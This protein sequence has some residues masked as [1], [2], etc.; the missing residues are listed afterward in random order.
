MNEPQSGELTLPVKE[1]VT[2]SVS[3]ERNNSINRMSGDASVLSALTMDE[4]LKTMG[5]RSVYTTRQA[6]SYAA[7]K[8]LITPRTSM[9]GRLSDR[10]KELQLNNLKMQNLPLCGRQNELE[11]LTNA[12]STIQDG[13]RG[14][15]L[16]GGL[17]GTG[18]T[19]LI[20]HDSF[21][22]KVRAQGGIFVTAKCDLREQNEPFASVQDAMSLLTEKILLLPKR[23][24]QKPVPS[25]QNLVMNVI[26]ESLTGEEK[27]S[28]KFS[29]SSVPTD[30]SGVSSLEEVQEKLAVELTDNEWGVLIQTVP[31]MEALLMARASAEVGVPMAELRLQQSDEHHTKVDGT[32]L[33]TTINPLRQSNQKMDGS[34][35]RENSD[36][37]KYAYRHFIRS[38]S[39]LCP[40]VIVFDDCQWQDKASMEWMKSILTDTTKEISSRGHDVKDGGSPSLLIV[41]SY[42][43]EEVDDD[44]G[45]MRMTKELN[46]LQS[47]QEK[48]VNEFNELSNPTKEIDRGVSLHIQN[49]Q[50]GNLE[51]GD[52]VGILEELLNCNGANVEELAEII[53]KKTA[54]NAFFVVQL[55]VRLKEDNRFTFNIGLMKWT[56]DCS[57]IRE[58]YTATSNVADFLT[59]RMKKSGA[60]LAILPIAAAL[61]NEFSPGALQMVIDRVKISFQKS[62]N[63]QF[64]S[65]YDTKLV[66]S[67]LLQCVDEGL[68]ESTSNGMFKFCHDKILETAMSFLSDDVKVCIGDYFLDQFDAEEE[69]FGDAFY[70]LLSLV[71]QRVDELARSEEKKFR[72]VQ[73]NTLA[74]EKALNCAAFEP[75]SEFLSNAIRCLPSDHWTKH[76]DLSLHIFV[77][78]GAAAFNAGAGHVDRVKRYTDEVFAQ[79]DV[80]LLDK[81]DLCYTMMD[82]YDSAFTAESNLANY[83]FGRSLLKDFGCRFPKSSV[84]VLLRTLSGLLA[85]KVTLKKKLSPQILETMPIS[86]DRKLMAVMKILDKF[87]NAAFHSKTDLLPLVMFRQVQYTDKF[88]LSPY[89]ALAYPLLGM[90]FCSMQDFE[91]SRICAQAGLTILGRCN[92]QSIASRCYLLVYVYNMHW[93]TPL[94]DLLK[95]L[96][97]GYRVGMTTG[98]LYGALFCVG[99]Y[100]EFCFWT[101]VELTSLYTDCATYLQQMEDYEAMKHAGFLNCTRHMISRLIGFTDNSEEDDIEA[102]YMEVNDMPMMCA[103][104]RAQIYVEC[105]LG[106]HQR[107]ADLG[108]EWQPIIMERLISQVSIV[109]ITFATSLSCMAL[110]RQNNGRGPRKYMKMGAKCRK[111]IKTYE[112]KLCPNCVAH[113]ALLDAEW[114]VLKKEKGD[115]RVKFEQ[116]VLLAGRRGLTHLQALAN[117]RF[118][119]YMEEIGDDA[120]TCYRYE[121]AVTLYSEWGANSKVDELHT[122]LEALTQRGITSSSISYQG[123]VKSP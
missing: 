50:L 75:A 5:E 97:E 24:K 73:L 107:A 11:A 3:S 58:S 118:A 54:G 70:P 28:S 26:P 30:I 61:G 8:P 119:I 46:T 41:A 65:L 9:E 105:F 60:A 33:A 111:Q 102:L 55:L 122:K 21:Q 42:R 90:I 89:A 79:T 103:L 14:L 15:F 59:D 114:A 39:T 112:A 100:V 71:N 115:L 2:P 86:T 29:V 106:N 116:A 16:V 123:F 25:Q 47:K 110:L 36:Q 98:T 12:F 68:V 96:L 99:F 52:I 4:D 84:G 51:V 85:A 91:A 48:E 83:E 1:L 44:H 74:G 13:G 53:H 22:K 88:G 66:N 104:R 49:I 17:S 19:S 23:K 56:W 108:L 121:K 72:V 6:L 95:P 92:D 62:D 63:A 77:M 80:P 82:A 38:I 120:E 20:E 81:V 87:T 113:A 34:S 76:R 40:L 37:M 32:G 18:K 109:E 69:K 7:N 31:A 43:S 35:M 101:G 10:S 27:T 78:A 57:E 64:V 93:T 45:L 117:E 94:N 67:P